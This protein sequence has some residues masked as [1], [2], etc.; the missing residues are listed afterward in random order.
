MPCRPHQ[1]CGEALQ[2]HPPTLCLSP[3]AFLVALHPSLLWLCLGG[4]R[5]APIGP[6]LPLGGLFLTWVLESP[7]L[8][9]SLRAWKSLSSGGQGVG[10]YHPLALGL[11]LS[12]WN[13]D[14]PG[15]CRMAMYTSCMSWTSYGTPGGDVGMDGGH[16][17]RE[18]LVE[19]CKQCRR[20]CPWL[21]QA[22]HLH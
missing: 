7:S 16:L 17:A 12:E 10:V 1:S 2:T 11:Y 4:H 5:D 13:E 18:G 22:R 20:V 14:Q 8:R 15:R 9:F 3:L 21:R 19:R 6:V